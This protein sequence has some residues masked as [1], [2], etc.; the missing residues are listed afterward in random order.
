M[1][2]PL[3][4]LSFLYCPFRSILFAQVSTLDLVAFYPFNGNAKDESGNGNNGF[5]FGATL[6][7]D[8]FN[9]PGSAYY[10]DGINDYIYVPNASI[11][12][13]VQPI[14]MSV[15]FKTDFVKPFASLFC[16]GEPDEPRAG[17]LMDINQYNQ[18]RADFYY[19]HQ[20]S[21]FVYVVTKN[22]VVDNQWHYMVASYDGEIAKIYLDGK[23]EHRRSN[24]PGV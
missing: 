14:T 17:Y 23:L 18:G 2:I 8:R 1:E 21:E 15:W 5:V 10:F 12:Q 13:I 11:L 24:L 19:N 20:T 6:T 7:T 9:N 16:K 3:V 22:N 4:I